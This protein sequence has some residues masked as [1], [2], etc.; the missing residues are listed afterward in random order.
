MKFQLH[1]DKDNLRGK[2]FNAINKI[3]TLDDF[4]NNP[5]DYSKGYF[6][7]L[8]KEDCQTY[9]SPMYMANLIWFKHSNKYGLK[10]RISQ[11]EDYINQMKS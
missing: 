7:P 9:L 4:I 11:R 10:C 8:N 6:E 2:L 3:K 5:G 1:L